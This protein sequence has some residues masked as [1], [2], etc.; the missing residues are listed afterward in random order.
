LDVIIRGGT[1]VTM[2]AENR[3]L[4]GDLHIQ[5][6]RISALGQL[7]SPDPRARVIR[8]DG[9]AVIPGLIQ[10]HVHLCQT[11][12]RGMA[13]ELPLLPWL[14]ERI[15]PLEAAHNPSS[16]RAS[17]ELGLAEMLKAGTSCILDMGTVHHQDS[18]FDAMRRSG[19]RGF[20]GKAMMDRGRSVPAGLREST[21]QSLDSSRALSAKWHGRA[22]GRLHYAYAPRFILSCSPT[23]LRRTARAA[24]DEGVLIHTHAAE[25]RAER[26]AVR[27]QLG[28][29]DI[30]ALEGFGIAGPQAV[31]AHGVQLRAAEIRRMARLGTRVVHCPSANLKLS[32]GLAPLKRMLQAGLVVGIG[33]DGAPCNNRM[34][35]WTEIRQA[36]LLAM[37]REGDAAAV[38]ASE[39]LGLATRRGAEVLGL[40]EEIGSLEVGKK[41]D[42]TIVDLNQLHTAPGGDVISQ[43]VYS[44]TASDV[45]HVLVDGRQVVRDG[46]LQTLDEASILRRARTHGRRI[47]ERAGLSS[48]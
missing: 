41:A 39:A 33:A 7:P 24:K 19:I 15:W 45:R 23:L 31:L 37:A 9:C 32:S 26:E 48:S 28:L 47:L 4:S 36:A 1:I 17:A 14:K 22:K 20:S 38:T 10:S 43:L 27:A 21:R 11:L 2:D 8:A 12:F 44:S 16:M 30:E 6:D 5:G 46:E 42:V 40:Q 35:P 18:V 29:D 25:H 13:N 3:V 34:D